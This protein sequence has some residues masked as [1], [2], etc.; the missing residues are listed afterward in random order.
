MSVRNLITVPNLLL[1]QK[2][3]PIED[4]S[5]SVKG[6]AEF[7]LYQLSVLQAVGLAAPQFG[8]LARLIVVKLDQFT[9]LAIVNPQ[10]I[11]EKGVHTALEG[12]KSIPGRQYWVKRP[13]IIKVKGQDLMGKTITI[14]GRDL[15]AQILKHE[16][17]HLDGILI[18]AIGTE[19]SV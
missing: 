13:K 4:I 5:N 6:L 17:D 9:N 10:I 15:L 1:R 2:S 19:Q 18:D 16:I 8:E 11:K 7:M 12:C 3:L 14:K